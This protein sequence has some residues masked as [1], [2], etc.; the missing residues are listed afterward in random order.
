MGVHLG[1]GYYN[2]NSG[3]YH[4][5]HLSYRIVRNVTD[6]LVSADYLE[7]PSGIGAWHPDP[8]ERRTTRFRATLKLM[9]LCDEHGI[10]RYMIVPYEN[11]EVIILRQRK[12]HRGSPGE[13]AEYVDTAFTRLAR[14]N[15][16]NINIFISSHRINLDITDDQEEALMLRLRGRDDGYIDFTKTRLVRIF[17]NSS[18]ENGGRFYGGF[19]QQIPGDWRTFITINGKRTVQLDYSGMHF[20]I[21][22]AKMG[23]DTPMTDPYALR[24][25]GGHLR[26]NIKTAFNII[27]N[28]NSRE[29]AIAA[30][31]HRIADGEL[32]RELIG[33]E[34]IISAFEDAHPLIRDK[35]A[36][37]EGV[38]GQF[39]DS[40]V[41]ERILLKGIDI[42]LCILPIHDGFITTKGDEFVLEHLMNEAFRE[43]TGHSAKLK[44]ESFD[45][46]VLPDDVGEGPHWITRPGGDVERDAIREGKAIAYSEIVSGESLWRRLEEEDGSKKNKID[47]DR[48]WKLVH[49]R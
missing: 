28:C 39:V 3:R 29:E 6:F 7:M 37:G 9:N 1:N 30:I 36:S 48:E 22:Y 33:G 13:L 45:L 40:Q 25:F 12:K 10:S 46:S 21:M 34:R 41:A 49:C 38:R 2:E 17:N 18:F 5:K 15:L 42:G 27:I 47:R 31:D 24:D 19:W 26:G 20:A 44:P 35:I 23:I 16:E 4:P 8:G 14:R 43:I 11:P 32:S